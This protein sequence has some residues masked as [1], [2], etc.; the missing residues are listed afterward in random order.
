MLKNLETVRRVLDRQR[1]KDF[2]KDFHIS[3]PVGF[4]KRFRRREDVETSS[5]I[6]SVFAIGPRYA[7]FRTLEK[8][9]DLIGT[10]PHLAIINLDIAWL[11]KEMQG[12]IQFAYKN[13]TGNDI[14][15][16]L[17]VLKKIL[18]D[19]GSIE[20]AARSSMEAGE[21]TAFGLL[22]ALLEQMKAY[23]IPASLGGSL[24]PRAAALLASPRQGSACKRM[25]MFLRWM[26]R[27]DEIDFGIY[28]WFRTDELVVPLDVN[29]SRAARQL[30]LT[31]RKTDNWKTAVEITHTLKELDPVDPVKYDV[32]LFLYGIKLRKGLVAS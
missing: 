29:V 1:R 4:P 5:F 21:E 31:S 25:N 30:N 8:V 16:I 17:F 27:K 11:K 14:A 15:Q 22:T 10:S 19:Y 3:D 23:R 20:S 7:I 24:T 2:L 9:F 13:I 12:Y 18:N 26:T 28:K 6:A 32:P